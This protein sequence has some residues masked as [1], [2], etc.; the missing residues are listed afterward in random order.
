[1]SKLSH[2]CPVLVVLK[3]RMVEMSVQ[4]KEIQIKQGNGGTFFDTLER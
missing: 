1:M 4:G 3:W 2:V